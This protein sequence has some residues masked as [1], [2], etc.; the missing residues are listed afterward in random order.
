MTKEQKTIKTDSQT[1][2][3]TNSKS[4]QKRKKIQ[5]LKLESQ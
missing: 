1:E 2:K 3:E 5:Q 4:F